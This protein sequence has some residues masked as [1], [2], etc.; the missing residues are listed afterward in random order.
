MKVLKMQ[1]SLDLE[2]AY[3]MDY[4]AVQIIWDFVTAPERN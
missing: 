3:F 1:P 4:N 2:V